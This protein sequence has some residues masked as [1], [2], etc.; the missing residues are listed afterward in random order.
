MGKLL[1]MRAARTVREFC[2]LADS[3]IVLERVLCSTF[4]RLGAFANCLIPNAALLKARQTLLIVE[5]SCFALTLF[6]GD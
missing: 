4:D 6:A 3:A 1:G 5:R 2:K